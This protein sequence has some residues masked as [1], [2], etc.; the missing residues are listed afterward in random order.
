MTGRRFIGICA[1]FIA[2]AA[3]AGCYKT[4]PI[5]ELP[6]TVQSEAPQTA[7]LPLPEIAK[8]KLFQHVMPTSYR[9]DN[10]M[11]VYYIYNPTLPLMSMKV[12][13]NSGSYDDP[14]EKSG[15]SSFTAAL[16]KEGANGK[17]AQEIS[18]AVE[19]IGATLGPGMKHDTASIYVESLTHYFRDAVDILSDIWLK[20]DFTQESF[21]RVKKIVLTR[22]R[23]REDSPTAVAKLAADA[24]FYG[25]QSPYGRSADGYISTIN[26]ISPDDIRARHADLFSPSRAAIF[27]TGNMAPE[28]FVGLMNEKFGKLERHPADASASP[29]E[30]IAAAAQKRLVIV[31]KPNA[32]QTVIRICEPGIASTSFK[33]VTWQ[34]VNIPFGDSFT[35]RLMQNIREDKGY[36][37]GANSGLV[38]LKRGGAFV[39]ASSVESAHA[40]AALK[41]FLH[42]LKRLPEGDFEEDE[43]AR[44]R[45]TW[46]SELIQLFETQAGALA[47]ISALYVNGKPMDAI[48][49]FAR[50]LETFDL[51]RFN[52][53]AREFPSIDEA[54]IVLVGDKTAILG[55]IA[56]MDLPEPEFYDTQGQRITAAADR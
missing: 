2:F 55:Q 12:V 52:E 1:F 41:E 29:Q 30:T 20:P 15:L 32:P 4:M 53:I 34:F 36:S 40:G 18:D 51:A 38:S 47:T 56:D 5:N 22:L 26:A 25:D 14:K 45:E 21:E 19:Q 54:T 10:G 44:A 8:P 7:A 46:R 11:D 42:E 37:Y 9:L 27:G 50:E 28:A 43:F 24:A 39:S 13:F 31:D 33:T 17:S 16:L 35:S 3:L 48:N 49:R 6:E 23:Q